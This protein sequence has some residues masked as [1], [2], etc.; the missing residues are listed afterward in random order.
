MAFGM[1][2]LGED[3]EGESMQ[4]PV[5]HGNDIVSPRYCEAPPR[6][7]VVLDIHDHEDA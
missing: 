4:E 1:P 5:Y 3:R 6:A 7:K 2:I